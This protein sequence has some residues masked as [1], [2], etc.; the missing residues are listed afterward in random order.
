MT[1]KCFLLLLLLVPFIF[2]VPVHAAVVIN[3]VYPKTSDA[4]EEWV[5]LYNTGPQSVSLNLWKLAHTAGD[6]KSFII[7][8]SS[9]IQPQSFLTLGESQTGIDFSI[10]GDTAQLF[11]QNGTMVDSQSYPGILGY[12]TSMGRSIDGAGT[13]AICTSATYNTNNNCPAP[14]PTVTP[15]PTPTVTPAPSPTPTSAPTPTPSSIPTPTPI[16]QTFGSLLPSPAVSQVLGATA[17]PTSTPTPTPASM[18]ILLLNIHTS[19]IAYALLAVAAAALSL[20]ITIWL[21]RKR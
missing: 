12:N 6:A 5:E 9:I 18:D 15:M 11:D 16:Q 21:T 20:M 14:S 1:N 13:W 17:I 2:A 10:N 8:A 4:T 3:E 19:W 7:N